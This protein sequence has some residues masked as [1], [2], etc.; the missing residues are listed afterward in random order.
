MLTGVDAEMSSDPGVLTTI[1]EATPAWLTRVLRQGGWLPTGIVRSLGV[2]RVHEEQLHTLG[3][4]LRAEYDADAPPTA[5]GRLFLKLPRP[6][7][8]RAR[9]VRRGMPEVRMYRALAAD[10]GEL[11][12]IPCYDAA[13]DPELGSYHLL[14]ADLSA[15]HE[16][17]ASFRTIAHRYVEETA[18]ALARFHAHWWAHPAL[19]RDIG[20]LPDAMAA[21]AACARLRDGFPEFATLLG[22]R[23]SDEDRGI[24]ERV[25]AALPA[26]RSRP[27]QT[28][29]HGDAHFWNF[30][31]PRAPQ[32]G[33]TCII[34]WHT[35]R[36]GRGASD[37]AYTIVLRYPA[38]TP[39]NER[40][41]VRRYHEQLCA[42]GVAGYSWADCWEDYRR[43]AAEWVLASLY[44]WQDGLPED[45][46]S[47]FIEPPL[48]AYRDLAC[49]DIFGV[50]SEMVRRSF[51]ELFG[52]LR[53]ERVL[54]EGLEYLRAGRHAEAIATLTPLIARGGAGAVA[55]YGRAQAY[56]ASG[57]PDEALA[58]LDRAIELDPTA[59]APYRARGLLR[60]KLGRADEALADLDRAVALAPT[61]TTILQDRAMTHRLTGRFAEAI[62][63]YSAALVLT[64]D[65]P[66]VWHARGITNRKAG[67]EAAAVA[68]LGETIR[69]NPQ[70][71]YAFYN[72]GMALLA[73]GRH[74]EAIPDL[75][76]TV[77][78]NPV[79]AEAHYHLA[80]CH[81]ATGNLD[82]AQA[83]LDR[84][85]VLD[86]TLRARI[87]TEPE[88]GLGLGGPTTSA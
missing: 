64:P 69:R 60:R 51:S 86:P 38:R 87:A 41:L 22:D 59:A 68:D 58:D 12:I 7:G 4:F 31:Y 16:Q 21:A 25:L 79:F 76:Q 6:G 85:L 56:T 3:Y 33:Q 27:W 36:L 83:A 28:M 14:L 54:R 35:Y 55:H 82:A 62:V 34:D 10:Q 45:F 48:R 13:Y 70:D 24:Y 49:D 39:E 57:R 23:L 11:P 88:L 43:A 81:A 75:A 17:P 50:T 44:W 67:D 72:R 40:D 32:A 8:D 15:T 78:F 18:N 30:L 66:D 5:P 47:M 84:A 46:W 1:E 2:E 53:G 29:L 71:A 77:A 37:L 20:E 26:L 52:R 63:D 73:L 19:G 74:T 80:R 42:R 65:D 9:A 61:D